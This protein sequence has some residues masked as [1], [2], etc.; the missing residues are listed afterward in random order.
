LPA[1]THSMCIPVRHGSI[2][3]YCCSWRIWT[4]V[5][6]V[7]VDAFRVQIRTSLVGIQ[8]FFN[9]RVVLWGR[10]RRDQPSNFLAVSKT[11]E[12]VE[13]LRKFPP[14][15]VECVRNLLILHLSMPV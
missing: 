8:S 5:A 11:P 6:I 14:S 10:G 3:H 13:K 4:C 1:V 2:S 12:T 15:R 7:M 9:G